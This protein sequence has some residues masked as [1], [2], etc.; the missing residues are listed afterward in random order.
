MENIII[1][2]LIEKLDN[3]EI[4][5]YL[6]KFNAKSEKLN[7][8]VLLP[9]NIN[10]SLIEDF[11]RYLYGFKD[12][13]TK[14]YN[15][16]G[17]SN[18]IL[19]EL[20]LTALEKRWNT[21][22]DTISRTG[23]LSQRDITSLNTEERLSYNSEELNLYVTEIKDVRDDSYCYFVSRY[24]NIQRV[25]RYK[26]LFLDENGVFKEK[27]SNKALT[28]NWNVDVAI[29]NDSAYILSETGFNSIFDYDENL[30][31]IAMKTATERILK[32][33]IFYDNSKFLNLLTKKYA[34]RGIAKISKDQKYLKA[35]ENFDPLALKSRILEKCNNVFSE[36]DFKENLLNVTRSNG[37]KIINLISK[38]LKY[39]IF[40]DK[41]EE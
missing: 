35:I 21:L 4:N 38:E 33:K 26:K 19:P 28:I 31:E 3:A 15:P 22:Y 27:K 8:A 2:T 40:E 1:T 41:V 7:N 14:Q 25:L 34:Y 24:Q 29:L 23:E 10:T 30:K 17:N 9:D 18:E 39:N 37:K 5:I 12:R 6:V 20:S 16:N 11:K 36:E 32:W 13:E